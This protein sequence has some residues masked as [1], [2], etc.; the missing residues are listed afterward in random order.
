MWSYNIICVCGSFRNYI[1][2]YF[3][4]TGMT[5]SHAFSCF[6]WLCENQTDAI[7]YYIDNC[8]EPIFQ[9]LYYLKYFKF[10]NLLTSCFIYLATKDQTIKINTYFSS[11]VSYKISFGILHTFIMCKPERF[12]KQTTRAQMR[13][14]AQ[15]LV[16][17][18]TWQVVL[19]IEKRAKLFSWHATRDWLMSTYTRAYY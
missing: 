5:S 16:Q 10:I 6:P 11:Q 13:I 2:D 3:K 19:G 15:K 14:N 7:E 8:I 1:K 17:S 18:H 4:W 9:K 12:W